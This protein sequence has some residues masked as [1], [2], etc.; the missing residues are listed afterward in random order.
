MKKIDSRLS[1]ELAA[2]REKHAAAGVT[3]P[4][5]QRV[6]VFVQFTGDL[7][8]IRRHGL[9]VQTVVGDVAVGTAELDDIE[10]IAALEN[11]ISIGSEGRRRPQL[12]VSV[13]EIRAN[14]VWNAPLSLK[15]ENVIVGIVDTGIDIFHQ[16]FRDSDGKTRI[17]SILDMTHQRI[18]IIGAPT[19]G[20]FKLSVTLPGAAALTTAPLPHNAG[21][22]QIAAAFAAL[23]GITFNDLTV[24][25]GPLP[26]TP[27]TVGFIGKFANKSVPLMSA[28]STFT[29][30]TAPRVDV[31]GGR[32]FKDDE[33]NHALTAYPTPPFHHT[34]H[35]GHGTQVAGIAAGDGS[36]SGGTRTGL[37]CTRD[38]TYIGVAPRA[39]LVIVKTTFRPYDYVTGVAHVFQVAQ[40]KSKAA[41][42]NLSFGGQLGA[43]D[44]T[45]WDEKFLDDLLVDTT[46]PARPPIAGRAIVVAAGNDGDGG[47]HASGHVPA[48]GR[49]S[50]QFVVPPGD[51]EKDYFDL[52]YAG[53]GRLRFTLTSPLNAPTGGAAMAAVNPND[54]QPAQTIPGHSVL[55]HSF[56]NDGFNNK[57]EI[58]FS[59][60]P[61]PPP[62]GTA[63]GRIATGTWTITLQETAGSDVDFDCWIELQEKYK[64]PRFLDVDRDRARTL[65]IPTTARNVISVGAYDARHGTLADFSSV[66]PA[67]TPA[68]APDKLPPD[69]ATVPDRAKPDIAAPGVGVIAP[70]S[71]ER[72]HWY[73]CDCCQ[74]FY[75][76]E[77]GTSIAAPH[78]TGV[79]ALMLQRNKTLN[80]E[81][82]RAHL[83]ASGAVS[84]TEPGRSPPPPP[85][86]PTNEWGHGKIEA[87]RAVELAVPFSPVRLQEVQQRL[88]TTPIGQTLTALVSTHFDEVLRLI[89]R[90]RRVATLW[91]RIGGPV[92]VRHVLTWSGAESPLL[93]PR[94]VVPGFSKYF[95][96]LLEALA[97][98]GSTQL[99]RDVADYGA[100]VAAI[101]GLSLQQLDNPR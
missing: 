33:I 19:G 10:K 59:I 8:K 92:M 68:P 78:I 56:L 9:A 47:L 37:D 6:G 80:F 55:I 39:D 40:A 42:V 2:L 23:P 84:I 32:E 77:D 97:R 76:A 17:L 60:A 31:T 18:T 91:H 29:G 83:R 54:A 62:P 22:F 48:N 12:K 16:S 96:R 58:L 38:D 86:L 65:T 4:L 24:A 44:G 88:V 95:D 98:F 69:P 64:N 89:N 66:G 7:D 3:G 49:I 61:T 43:H 28:S 93:P 30:G 21:L 72:S 82:I 11:V 20:T 57:H 63:A 67:L 73:C 27:V 35:A 46:N 25:G 74:A 13:P 81:E 14:H 41:V 79:V 90:N 52:W 1:H 53:S 71:G 15:G 51:K 87:Q 26:G 50:F 100:L 34:D 45:S 5:A 85:A 36:Q 70:R 101:P 75:V 94:A 99:Q